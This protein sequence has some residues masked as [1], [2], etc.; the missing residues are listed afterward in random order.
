MIRLYSFLVCVLFSG[1]LSAQVLITA[2]MNGKYGLIDTN[3]VWM[4]E[5]QYDSLGPFYHQTAHYF[6]KGKYGL[7]N[8]KGKLLS[9]PA[10]EEISY[11]EEGLVAVYNGTYWGFIDLQGKT[12]IEPQFLEVDDF[13]EGLAGGSKLEDNWGY[14]DRS[15]KWAIAPM[16]TFVSEFENG[17]A[18]VNDEEEE[19]YINKKGERIADSL[20][21][22][23][24][25]RR[26]MAATGKMGIRKADSTWLIAPRFESLSLR[27]LSCY[28][29]LEN[30]LWGLVDTNDKVVY[31]AKFEQFRY[32]S[33][34]LAAVKLQGKW[35][36][37]DAL[38]KVV[39]PFIFDDANYFSHNRA[40][41]LFD[42][43]WGLIN[44]AGE[45]VVA[46]KFDLLLGKY[47]PVDPKRYHEVEAEAD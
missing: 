38:G 33:E 45:F 1:L 40:A 4:V 9:P 14:L 3:G 16:F 35:G 34:G 20:M 12:V 17:I 30:G 25:Y 19:F 28:F 47:Q 13:Y 46:P 39:I 8:W 27:S 18:Y 32:F 41:T 26:E 5:A 44:R 15:G 7:I 21:P 43:R 6:N 42:G 37:I 31:P 23:R 2:K 36:Y 11:E 10:W 22:K 29:F 24:K